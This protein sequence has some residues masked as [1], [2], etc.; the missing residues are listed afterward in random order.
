MKRRFYICCI[1]I[2]TESDVKLIEGNQIGKLP[3]TS[4]LLVPVKLEKLSSEQ[5]YNVLLAENCVT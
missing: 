4:P 1:I 3:E 2:K 5:P